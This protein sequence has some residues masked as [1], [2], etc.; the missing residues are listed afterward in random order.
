MRFATSNTVQALRTQQERPSAL[1]TFFSAR[2]VA[3]PPTASCISVVYITDGRSNDP[4][5]E[6]CKEVQCLHNRVGVETFAIGIGNRVS[7][8]ELECI[9]GFSSTTSIFRFRDFKDFA[10]TIIQDEPAC[11]PTST[12]TSVWP[13]PTH[14]R[15]GEQCNLLLWT[16]A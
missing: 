15:P 14:S 5:R 16:V 10:A 9:A 6:V 3:S 4:V 2:P 8:S 13:H 12:T 7:Q 1:A 11:L